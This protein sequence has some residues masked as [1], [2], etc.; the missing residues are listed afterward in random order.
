M[1]GEQRCRTC[2]HWRSH[3]RWGDCVRAE[4]HD[5]Q[6]DVYES[7]AY[8]FAHRHGIAELRTLAEFG[9]VQWEAKP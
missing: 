7:S 3:G 1:S 2:Q 8:A 5:G 4:S 6:P 9:C